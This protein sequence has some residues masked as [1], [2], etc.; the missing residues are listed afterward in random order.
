MDLKTRLRELVR[1]DQSSAST[2]SAQR[3]PISD[4]GKN[5]EQSPHLENKDN[6]LAIMDD[7]QYMPIETV[8]IEWEELKS[9]FSGA[10]AD[11]CWWYMPDKYK[12]ALTKA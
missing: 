7:W 4:H 8:T 9:R 2:S 1:R 10:V 3:Q 5:E 12:S 11:A 6:A